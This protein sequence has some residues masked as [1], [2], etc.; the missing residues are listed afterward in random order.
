MQK[1]FVSR[2]GIELHTRFWYSRH[3]SI[4]VLPK[5]WRCCV[6]VFVRLG[7]CRTEKAQERWFINVKDPSPPSRK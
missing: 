2:P 5:G 7:I 1:A 6:P 4:C 3:D